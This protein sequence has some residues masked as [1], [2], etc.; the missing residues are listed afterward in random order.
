MNFIATKAEGETMN[1]LNDHEPHAAQFDR[2]V[3]QKCFVCGDPVGDRCFCQI[4]R[5]EE[6][7]IML[8][9]PNCTIEYLDS[10]QALVDMDEQELRAFE[11]SVHLFVGEDKPWL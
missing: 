1:S 10:A 7:P 3:P 5:K 11:K 8:C 2:A 9:S 4:R 6:G